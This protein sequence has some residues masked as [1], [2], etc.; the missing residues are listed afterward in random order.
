[1]GRPKLLVN[2]CGSI[3]G[4]GVHQRN[5]EQACEPCCIAKREYDLKWKENN[6]KYEQNWRS[7]NKDKVKQYNKKS[8]EKNIEYHRAYKKQWRT[9]NP[10]YQRIWRAENPEQAKLQ[11]RESAR[12]RRAL[13]LNTLR[14]PYKESE[15]LETYGN[16]CHI[17]Q[18]PID[19]ETPRNCRGEGWELGL[20]L[21]HL[22]PLSKGGTDTLENIRPAHAL[23]NT[24][25]HSRIEHNEGI[26]AKRVK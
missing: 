12:K 19:L 8:Y 26:D 7:A 20:H 10:E 25:K 6:P 2:R 17:C 22:V 3:S 1:M 9:K 13:E 21:D 24:R 4:W 5:K 18:Q 15:V 23:C 16:D 14:E 11:G